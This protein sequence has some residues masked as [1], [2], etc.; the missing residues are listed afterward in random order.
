MTFF[1]ENDLISADNTVERTS[2]ISEIESKYTNSVG[3]YIWEKVITTKKNIFTM[4]E[5][6]I[7][8]RSTDKITIVNI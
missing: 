1:G 5:N 7:N 4:L 8:F 3:P 6:M 2:K